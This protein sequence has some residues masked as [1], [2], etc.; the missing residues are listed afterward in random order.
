MEKEEVK[1]TQQSGRV[2]ELIKSDDFK[3]LLRCLALHIKELDTVRNVDYKQDYQSIAVEQL[4]KKMAIEIIE[5]WL[6]DILGIASY[7]DFIDNNIEKTNDIV[8]RFK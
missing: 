5:R 1:K 6:D 8:K 4:A 2:K 7:G 3:D